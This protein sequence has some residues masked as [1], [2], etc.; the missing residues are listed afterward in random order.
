LLFGHSKSSWLVARAANPPIAA[1]AIMNARSTR[2]R[3]IAAGLLGATIMDLRTAARMR[4]H[5]HDVD[6][7]DPR[8]RSTAT[9]APS[10]RVGAP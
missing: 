3:L 8:V 4:S 5:E 6:R 9:S 2:A 10:S 7:N 1:V